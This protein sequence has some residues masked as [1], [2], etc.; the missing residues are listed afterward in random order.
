MAMNK[1][2]YGLRRGDAAV[3]SSLFFGGVSMAQ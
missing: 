2:T 1:E 3:G